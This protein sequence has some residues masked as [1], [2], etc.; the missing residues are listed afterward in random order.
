MNILHAL[1][2]L[3]VKLCHARQHWV[4]MLL[5]IVTASVTVQTSV[6]GPLVFQQPFMFSV[7]HAPATHHS[8]HS[9]RECSMCVRNHISLHSM[10]SAVHVM[11]PTA[12]TLDA[13]QPLE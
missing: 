13:M 4:I 5:S 7:R 12:Q 10:E 6:E 3:A 1:A 2:E 8:G 9:T 11:R